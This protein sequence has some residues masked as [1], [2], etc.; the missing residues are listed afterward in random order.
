MIEVGERDGMNLVR[1]ELYPMRDYFAEKKSKSVAKHDKKNR[2]DLESLVKPHKSDKQS[3]KNVSETGR[4]VEKQKFKSEKL[5]NDT[6]QFEICKSIDEPDKPD[7]N[8]LT[9]YRVTTPY[10]RLVNFDTFFY[11]EVLDSL[12]T[13]RFHEQDFINFCNYFSQLNLNHS[14][15]KIIRSTENE[16]GTEWIFC[17]SGGTNTSKNEDKTVLI[18]F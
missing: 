18:F 8:V 3:V 10:G 6:F 7:Y 4:T 14:V 9:A 15:H 13:I 11:F 16:Q 5:E 2:T 17:Y 12:F 1:D